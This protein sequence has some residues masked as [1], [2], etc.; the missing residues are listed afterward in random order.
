MHRGRRSPHDATVTVTHSTHKL[1]AAL[2]QASMIHIRPGRVAGRAR[3]VQRGVHD[4][5]LDLAAVQHHR[6]HGRVREDDG[7]RGPGADDECI[8]EA[9]DFRRAMLRLGR[10]LAQRR[11]DDWWFETWQADEVDGKPFVEA[12]PDGIATSS[13]A[14]LLR[15][16]ADLARLR[17]PRRPLLHA[18][19]D[20]GHDLDAR[21]R[22]A[23]G[24]SQESGIPA[25]IVTKF[26]GTLG[27]VVEKTEPYSLLTLFSLGITKGKWGSLVAGL[28]RFKELYDRE[29][30]ARRGAARPRRRRTRA[31]TSALGLRDLAEEMHAAIRKHR[32]LENLDGAFSNLPEP[33]LDAARNLR[34]TR[35][36]RRRAG[37]GR[38]AR[39]PHPRSAGG[40][41]PA[42]HP[43][44]DAR[45]ALRQ[46]DA[47]GRRL[48]ARSRGVRRELP[49]LRP[50]HPRR[51]GEDRRRPVGRTTRSTASRQ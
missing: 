2:S 37:S 48:P 7:R 26:L 32:I 50:R 16:G 14:W 42:G 47:R 27:I 9:I 3:A 43:A 33:V 25:A 6:L 5:H 40:A 18:R 28:M 19:P 46:G 12:D 44:L 38:E 21:R 30:P 13:D 17:R 1:L 24:S 34:P 20:Q 35:A 22:A 23:T 41:V 49:R 8:R 39:R 4:A 29:R 31:A 51:R 10:D 11:A 15:P 45:R 36:R